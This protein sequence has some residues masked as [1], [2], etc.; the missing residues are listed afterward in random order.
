MTSTGDA[1]GDMLTDGESA[2]TRIGSERMPVAGSNA[3]G[4]VSVAEQSSHIERQEWV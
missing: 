2:H 3:Y 1:V 4:Q